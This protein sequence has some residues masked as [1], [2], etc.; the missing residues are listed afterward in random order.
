MPQ[1]DGPRIALIH[2]LTES[3]APIHAAFADIWPQATLFDLL[4]S[5]LSADLERAG[6]VTPAIIERFVALGRYAES[7][8]G[9]GGRTA[10][11]LFTCSAFG[12]AIDAVKQAVGI[13][14]LRP[15]EAAFEDA[16]TIGGRVGLLVSFPP[17]LPALQAELSEM[18]RLRGVAMT[19]EGHIVEGALEALKRGD[20]SEHDY[21][22]AEAAARMPP[23]DCLVLGQFSLARAAPTVMQISGRTVLTTPTSAVLKLRELC[24]SA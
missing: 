16:V 9:E 13:P 20:A 14:V 15:N 2:A 8:A 18:A 3:V 23:T 19:V 7:S 12:P 10:A 6:E 22:V 11:I 17:S 24:A 4:D 1:T 5:S 21:L